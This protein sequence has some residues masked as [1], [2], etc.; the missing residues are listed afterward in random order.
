[1]AAKNS[2]DQTRRRVDAKAEKSNQRREAR[3]SATSASA[4]R[5][6]TIREN[7]VRARAIARG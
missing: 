5:A 6:L 2:D 1:M 4:N 7:F 3:Y